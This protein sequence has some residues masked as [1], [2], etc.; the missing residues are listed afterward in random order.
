MWYAWGGLIDAATYWY[1]EWGVLTP[2]YPPSTIYSQYCTVGADTSA[3]SNTQ[4]DLQAIC[5][6]GNGNTG[7]TYDVVTF[8]DAYDPAKDMYGT[9]GKFTI[10]PAPSLTAA[11]E[12]TSLAILGVGLFG[13]LSLGVRG[14][15]A[16]DHG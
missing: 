7:P 13:L 11:P 2:E 9:G 16:A 14:R 8:Q 1:A 12:P 10:L 5:H 15:L 3:S 4:E 6:D